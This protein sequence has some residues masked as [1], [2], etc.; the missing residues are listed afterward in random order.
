MSVDRSH[1][2]ILPSSLD[3][4]YLVRDELLLLDWILCGASRLLPNYE[5]DYLISGWNDNRIEIWKL[6]EELSIHEE[7]PT[8]C[9]FS[10]ND[11]T[12][13]VILALCPTT[14]RWGTGI[15][16]GYSLKTK[17]ARFLRGE[18]DVEVRT[19]Y[20]TSTDKATDS[21]TD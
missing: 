7:I 6:L 16:C 12:A 9:V 1:E 3:S 2:W 13:K 8:S 11:G 10:M 5:L 17:V 19:D 4:I 21:P 18:P 14:F 15:D 20:S